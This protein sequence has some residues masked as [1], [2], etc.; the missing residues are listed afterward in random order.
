MVVMTL[1]LSVQNECQQS[2][3]DFCSCIFDN[4]TA[5]GRH[6]VIIDLWAAILDI[7]LIDNIAT[8]S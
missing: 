4:Q 8:S 1:L 7:N 2:V 5:V 6:E 3:N